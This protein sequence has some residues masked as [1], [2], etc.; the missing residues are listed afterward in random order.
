M[1]SPRPE[2]SASFH[3][4]S[5]ANQTADVSQNHGQTHFDLNDAL[6]FKD[7]LIG[8][9]TRHSAHQNY[10]EQLA[11]DITE[12]SDAFESEGYAK[13]YAH[14]R[15]HARLV[16]HVLNV[17]ETL[18]SLKDWV[19]TLFS[20]DLSDQQREGYVETAFRGLL[21]ERLG[22]QAKVD[23]YLNQPSEFKPGSQ[24]EFKDFRQ[25]MLSYFSAGWTYEKVSATH[26]DLKNQ[27]LR[28]QTYA[29][30]LNGAAFNMKAYLDLTKPK[31]G[32][33]DPFGMASTTPTPSSRPP[34]VTPGIIT[35]KNSINESELLASTSAFK[36]KSTGA[37]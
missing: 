12:R 5:V 15:R 17:K 13:W 32:N 30:V 19:V 35:P 25:G 9:L 1:I 11:I 29:K 6:D 26:R 36:K 16:M 10:W 3:V 23:A 14:A 18:E 22:T 20:S 33:V 31:Y 21:Q 37:Q 8:S 4:E 34:K 7:D 28:V 2:P 24:D 27:A